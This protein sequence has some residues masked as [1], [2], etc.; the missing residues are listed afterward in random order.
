MQ[1][2]AI[3]RLAKVAAK[4]TL[5]LTHYGRKSGKPYDVTIWFVV[6]ADKIY[7][8]TANVERQWVRNVRKTPR[9]RLSIGGEIFDGEARFL[10]EP[11]EHN[12]AMTRVRRKYW[13][14]A[15]FIAVWRF[16]QRMRLVRDK[17]GAFEVTVSAVTSD[18]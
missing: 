6:D 7:L 13:M 12:R 4:Q 3:T 16:L 18:E 15:P 17:T 8:S 2:N 5:I 11:A 1:S 14:Y 10:T 9:V